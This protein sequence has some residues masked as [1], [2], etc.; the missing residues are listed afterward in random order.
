MLLEV[1]DVPPSSP[2]AMYDGAPTLPALDALMAQHGFSRQY[3][4]WNRWVTYYRELNCFYANARRA[5][6]TW[7]WA[8][9]NSQRAKSMVSYARDVPPFLDLVR[10]TRTSNA[11]VGARVPEPAR[12]KPHGARGGSAGR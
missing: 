11:S 8:T 5:G 4:E 2:L 10:Q 9:G 7:L 12:R 3:C 1:Q 6:S